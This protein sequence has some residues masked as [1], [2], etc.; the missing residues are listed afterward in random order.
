MGQE[1]EHK[2]RTNTARVSSYQPPL[3]SFHVVVWVVGLLL[4]LSKVREGIHFLFV[5]VLAF[6]IGVKKWVHGDRKR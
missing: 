4:V 3:P 6:W 2:H 1:V 5:G